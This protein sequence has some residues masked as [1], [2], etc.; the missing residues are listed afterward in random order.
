MHNLKKYKKMIFAFLVVF[1][2][3]SSLFADDSLLKTNYSFLNV[4]ANYLD[5]TKSTE[6][7]SPQRDFAYLELEGGAGFE[8]GDVYGY[9]DI[10]NP[11]RGYDNT[12]QDNRRYAFKPAMDIRLF[13]SNWYIYSQDFNLYSKDYHISNL[14]AGIS[15]KMVKEDLLFQP[16]LAPHYQESTYYS[17]FN[18]YMFGWI[19]NYD[20]TMHKEKFTIF[21]WHEQEFARDKKHYLA[22]DGSRTG[23]GESYGIQGSFE[24]WWHMTKRVKAGLQYR[25]ALNKLGYYGYQDGFIYSLRYY[26]KR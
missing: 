13:H 6:K 16:F 2:T 23:D 5:W 20:F 18:G 7:S 17:G 21:Q 8:W 26:F 4:S 9:F 3:C 25:Y 11:S 24:L 22:A 12:P 15:Y 10:E 1:L 19:L 14:I